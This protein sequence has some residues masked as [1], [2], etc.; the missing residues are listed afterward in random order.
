MKKYFILFV[1]FFFSTAFAKTEA[2]KT[3]ESNL[4]A[5]HSLKATYSQVVSNEGKVIEKSLGSFYLSKP[6]KFRLSVRLPAEQLIVSDGKTLWIYDKDLEQVT[7]RTLAKDITGMPALFLS[8][9]NDDVIK[10]YDVKLK[11]ERETEA[12]EL[13]PRNPDSQYQLIKLIFKKGLLSDIAIKDNL[14]HLTSL[15]LKDV[16]LNP[17]LSERLFKFKPPKGVDVVIQ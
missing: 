11:N 5:M 2:V 4:N 15:K 17:T 13:T 8:G 6:G 9:Y 7:Q 16:I 1:V 10:A 12:Y 14:E 3:L